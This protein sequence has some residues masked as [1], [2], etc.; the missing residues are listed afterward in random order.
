MWKIVALSA[1]VLL[2]AVGGTIGDAVAQTSQP[3]EP[4]AQ[5]REATA[6][7]KAA[8]RTKSASPRKRKTR[9]ASRRHGRRHAA[10]FK[11]FG[12][13]WRPFPT[14]DPKGYFYTPAGRGIC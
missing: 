14:R 3:R 7:P 5:P 11:C 10:A 8:P 9:H 6:T 12:Q 4:A 2:S 13:E 1:L